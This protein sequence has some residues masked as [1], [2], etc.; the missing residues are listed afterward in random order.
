[1]RSWL[2]YKISTAIAFLII[3]AVILPTAY[4]VWKAWKNTITEIEI[5]TLENISNESLK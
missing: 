2:E 5:R 3:F 4:F 1:M